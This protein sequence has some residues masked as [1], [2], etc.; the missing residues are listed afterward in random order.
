MFQKP[1]QGF[2]LLKSFSDASVQSRDASGSSETVEKTVIFKTGDTICL[3]SLFCP[4]SA[5]GSSFF[6][7]IA[8]K[9]VLE[10]DLAVN[11][12][13]MKVLY[14]HVPL[15]KWTHLILQLRQFYNSTFYQ[16]L[17]QTFHAWFMLLGNTRIGHIFVTFRYSKS[18]LNEHETKQK[19]TYINYFTD[20]EILFLKCTGLWSN[21]LLARIP[22]ITQY[23]NLTLF[24]LQV[25]NKQFH[26]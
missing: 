20:G 16:V 8:K 4:I 22:I 23:I 19:Y 12:I 7:L 9:D 18:N 13:V 5:V 6:L 17:S 14:C 3:N 26:N 24:K 15:W 25:K 1:D 11:G 10:G 21:S 2:D